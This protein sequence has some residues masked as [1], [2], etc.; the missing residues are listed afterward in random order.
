MSSR[1]NYLALGLLAFT[2]RQTDEA[3]RHFQAALQL[4]PSFAVAVGLAH[5]QQ[6]AGLT[7]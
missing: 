5:P 2:G 1:R 7:E 6:R 4:N 3:M